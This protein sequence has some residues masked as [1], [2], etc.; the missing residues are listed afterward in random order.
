MHQQM[1]RNFAEIKQT[2]MPATALRIVPYYHRWC[3]DRT[4]HYHRRDQM[5]LNW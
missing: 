2:P 3:V 1:Q 4:Q 5:D